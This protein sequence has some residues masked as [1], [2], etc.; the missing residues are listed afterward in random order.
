QL[1]ERIL[2]EIVSGERRICLAV[3]EP[4][5]GSDVCGIT[6][7][8]TKTPDDTHHIVN[9][10]KKWITNGIVSDYFMTAVRTGGPGASGLSMLLIPRSSGLRTR[11]IDVVS[12]PLPGTTY[13]TFEDAKVPI[14]YLVG[15]EGLGFRQ[16]MLNFNQERLWIAFQAGKQA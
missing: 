13:V 6:T 12:G 5:A 4:S 3:T 9:G 11:T 7:T 2:P 16:A 1:Q 10:E 14:S 15:N 8:A